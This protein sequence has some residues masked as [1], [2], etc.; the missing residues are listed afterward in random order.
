MK[1]H[2]FFIFISLIILS[3]CSKY[4]YV[5]LKYPNPPLVS[6]PDNI[7]DI[8]VVN[9][10]LTPKDNKKPIIDAII[11]GEVAGSDKAASDEA[12]KGVFDGLNGWHN[13]NVIIPTRTRLYGTGTR[14][15]P[16]LLGWP[17]VKRICD[18]SKAQALLV[19]ENFD[20]NSGILM[21]NIHNQVNAVLNGNTPPPI[22]TQVRMNVESFWRLYDPNTQKI[23]DEFKSINYLNFNGSV[24]PPE[25]LP[26]TAYASG[27]QYVNRFLPSY[28][29][30]R[31]DFYK[32]G[33]G[34][35]KSEFLKGFRR[36]E[37]ANWKG[38]SEIWLELTKSKNR[39]N[40]GKAC[41]N[42]A[43]ACEAL[44]NI[45]DAY[46]W[47]KKAYEDYGNRLG[48]D[49]ANKLKYRLNYE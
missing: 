7:H 30:V 2:Y 29:Y 16:E 44:G 37:V 45:K 19:L 22:S 33:K 13:F 10:S 35:D 20:S 26:Q 4:G 38:A 14:E 32:R 25:A 6:L 47:A 34:S 8:T 21:D 24:P 1:K 23:I 49:Y 31:R 41:L 46:S 43:V 15:T 5:S 40:A 3:S 9:R 42:M 39:K 12:I 36:S 11:T 18:S 48:R 17:L 28:Y 27:Q